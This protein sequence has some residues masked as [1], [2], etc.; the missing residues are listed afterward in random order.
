MKEEF[1]YDVAMGF[2]INE[3]QF[4]CG[5]EVMKESLLDG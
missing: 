3:F 2:V 1:A 4:P 5:K